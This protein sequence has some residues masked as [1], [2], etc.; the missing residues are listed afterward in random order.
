MRSARAQRHEPTN[1]EEAEVAGSNPVGRILSETIPPV[2]QWQSA[3]N[4]S[5][6]D[7]RGPAEPGHSWGNW[8][9]RSSLPGATAPG[10]NGVSTPGAVRGGGTAVMFSFVEVH[11]GGDQR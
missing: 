1:P 4:V 6:R 3:E 7:S 10:S 2:A 9:S 11:D 5:L 8:I